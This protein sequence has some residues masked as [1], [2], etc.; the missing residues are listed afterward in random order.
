[1]K[2]QILIGVVVLVIIGGGVGLVAYSNTPQF[3]GSCHIMTPFYTSWQESTHSE[4]GCLECHLPPEAQAKLWG[5]FQSLSRV[6][7]YVLRTYG[8]K[9]AAEVTDASCL[10]SGCHEQRLLAGK[11]TFKKGIIFD[12]QPHLGDLRRGKKLQCATC[13]S[14]IVQGQHISVTEDTCFLCHFKGA[15]DELGRSH[16]VPTARCQVCHE[17][18]QK[19]IALAPGLSYSHAGVLQ[20]GARCTDC[21]LETIVGT[22]E[23]PKQMCLKCHGEK[24]RLERYQAT[25]FIHKHHVE[26]RKVEC[27]ECH[28]E[29]QHRKTAAAPLPVMLCGECHQRNHLGPYDMY[30]GTGGRGIKDS[31]SV[32]YLAQVDCVACHLSPPNGRD[33]FRHSIIRKAKPEACNKCHGEDYGA[34][35][36]DWKEELRE[37][38]EKAS[39]ALGEARK[40]VAGAAQRADER[41]RTTRLLADLE[42]NVNFVKHA[43]GMHNMPYATAL[44]E[45]VSDQA[46]AL[47]ERLGR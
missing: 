19:E 27:F 4:V 12:H 29:I 42:F 47:N 33:G 31:P 8:T 25:E 30:R 34:M 24:E 39:E 26:L 45:Y 43:V 28:I 13:H 44:L 20:Y 1:M 16:D 10:R 36:A 7:N 38:E 22:G 6:V 14:Q 46:G 35:V 32:M 37:A 23:V 2:T 15:R 40:A 21:H 9:P 17:P 5:K 18:P 11:V 3:C 41:E